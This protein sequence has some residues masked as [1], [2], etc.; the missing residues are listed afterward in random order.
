MENNQIFYD[1]AM[2][3][4][5]RAMRILN[6]SAVVALLLLAIFIVEMVHK[7][8]LPALILPVER[9]AYAVPVKYQRY[10]ARQQRAHRHPALVRRG[11]APGQPVRAGFYVN[12]DSSSYSSLRRHMR[13]M[14]VLF[15]EW[16]HASSADGHIDVTFDQQA[17]YGRPDS[18]LAKWKKLDNPDLQIVPLVNNYDGSTWQGEAAARMFADPVARQ[19]F[20]SQLPAWLDQGNYHGVVIDFENIPTAAQPDYL[21]FV[22]ELHAVLQQH[23]VRMYL[24]LPVADDDYDLKAYAAQ[25]EVVLLMNYD[26]H[27]A[28]TAPGPLAS[29]D[30]FVKNVQAALQVIPREKVM[31]GIANYGYD[32]PEQQH[33]QETSVQHALLMAQESGADVHLDPDSLNPTFDYEDDNHRVHHVWFTDAV[34]AVD[35]M[36]GARQLGVNAFAIWRLGAADSSVWT[37]FDKFNDDAAVRLGLSTPAP[38]DEIDLEGKG[39]IIRVT[40]APQP[41]IRQVQIDPSSELITAERYSRYPSSYRIDQ[42]GDLPHAVALSFDDGP[43]PRWT[44]AILDILKQYNVPATFFVIGTNAERHPD[45]LTRMYQQGDEIGNH[46]FLHPDLSDISH[47]QLELELNSTERLL[48]SIVGVK[49]ILFRPPYGVDSTPETNDEVRPLA[50]VQ[51]LGYLIIGNSIDPHDWQPGTGKEEIVNGV[52]DQLGTGN[53]ILLHDSGGVRAATVAALPEIIEKARLRGYR[54]VSVADLLGMTRA[55]VM[56]ALG[57]WDEFAVRLAGAVFLVVRWIEQAIIWIFLLGIILMSARVLIIGVLAVWQKLRQRP[58][59]VPGYAPPLAVLIPAYNEEA[60]IATTVRSV[61]A[62][63]YANFRIIVVDDGSTDGTAALL[64]QEFGADPRVTVVK[65]SNG[66]KAVALNAAIA[67]VSEVA[68]VTIDADTSIAPTALGLLAAHLSDPEVGAVAGNAKVGNRVNLVTW[69]Q[70]GE[71]ITSQNL[72]RRALDVLNC[73]TVVPG[74]IGCWRTAIVR[75]LGG[76]NA[77]TAAEDA[78]LTFLIRRAGFRIL[79]EDGALAYTEAPV[80]IKA[81]MKQRFRWSYGMV[82]TVW[83]HRDLFGRGGTLGR[84]ALPNILIFQII[85]PLLGPVTDFMLLFALGMEW[86]NYRSH[87]QSWTPDSLYRLLFFFSVLMLVDMLGSLLAFALEHKEQWTL[88][89]GLLLQRLVYRHVMALVMFR[90]LKQALKGGEFHWGKLER[91]GKLS[92]RFV[93]K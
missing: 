64:E 85:L 80:T 86:F 87:P 3:R 24:S 5:K 40:S 59:A 63:D 18:N 70:A 48:E 71:Y 66:G 77:Q 2:R 76:F 93:A 54:F 29:Q 8:S 22:T 35:Q 12:W 50:T 67:M 56:P 60:V 72:E 89:G 7:E 17:E 1:P 82:Q 65:R 44:P 83:K 88:I 36:R 61:L 30:W 16:L 11:T 41:G 34:T 90:T 21:A 84:F 47:L 79:Y 23:H 6:V 32:W 33:G 92:E 58:P 91:T 4:W 43:D 51:A 20:E 78:D 49:T 81:L 39:D 74:A 19:R 13:D 28:S 9:S 15:A 69:F 27:E 68:F 73:I 55:Q 42:Y 62:S 10:K 45:L 37:V 31:L 75:Q 52:L 38:G 25:T 57:P 53:V 26:E 14:D 46:T